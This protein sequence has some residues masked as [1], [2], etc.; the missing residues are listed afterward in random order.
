V[1]GRRL[2]GVAEQ[3][4]GIFCLPAFVEDHGRIRFSRLASRERERKPEAALFLLAKFRQK[5]KLKIR[6]R[7][8][9]EG[10]QSPEVREKRTKTRK[11]QS[12]EW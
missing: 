10:F 3:K 4:L 6:K 11:Q 1:A 12:P 7:S 2:P 5:A 8:D 9:F